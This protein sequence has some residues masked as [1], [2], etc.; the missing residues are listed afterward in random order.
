MV[1]GDLVMATP[2]RWS[3]LSAQELD[4]QLT[5]LGRSLNKPETVQMRLYQS[6]YMLHGTRSGPPGEANRADRQE[7]HQ[8]FTKTYTQSPRE[9]SQR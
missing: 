3:T 1:T 7:L 6:G 4:A 2:S 5:A 9:S 8:S